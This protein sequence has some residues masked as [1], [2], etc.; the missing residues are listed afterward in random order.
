MKTIWKKKV[1]WFKTSKPQIV[2]PELE[3]KFTYMN[4]LGNPV[5]C[6]ILKDHGNGYVDVLNKN[7]VTL[8]KLRLT[9]LRMITEVDE[10]ITE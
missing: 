3:W 4:S 7:G 6:V 2:L 5:E 1:S 9:E 10:D 8:F